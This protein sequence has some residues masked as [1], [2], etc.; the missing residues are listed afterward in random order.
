MRLWAS[1]LESLRPLKIGVTS[2]IDFSSRSN[3]SGAL[4]SYFSGAPSRTGGVSASF[5]RRL[6]SPS[7]AAWASGFA[8]GSDVAEGGGVV[9]GVV[10]G[11]GVVDWGCAAAGV[12]G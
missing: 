3:P 5:D 7:G 9:G 6:G 12:G 10:V 2:S 1:V 8:C 11:G 4:N